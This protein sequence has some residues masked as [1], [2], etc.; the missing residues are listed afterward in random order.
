MRFL[1]LERIEK[2]VKEFMFCILVMEAAMIGVFCAL[3]FVLFYVFWE[4]MLIPMY[5][6]IAVWGGPNRDYASIKFFIYTLFGSVFM[7]AAIIA[8]YLV[9]GTFSIPR[10]CSGVIPSAL[11]CGYS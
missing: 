1:F 3:D 6:L 5:L 2:R 11:S 8:L 4:A 9:N 10:P 7:L